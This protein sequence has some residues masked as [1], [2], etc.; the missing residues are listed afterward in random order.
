MLKPIEAPALAA[1]PN[2]E[3]GFFTR[4]GGRS[5]GIYASLNCGTGSKD[6][7][8]TVLANRALVAGHL[9]AKPGHLLTC[10]QSHTALAVAISEPWANGAAPKAD[11]IVTRT[12][13]LAVAVLAADCAPILFADLDA[14]VIGAAHA[15]WR[16]AL[17]GVLEATIKAMEDL[18]AKREHIRAALGPCIGPEAYEVGP[19]FEEQFHGSD[20]DSAAFFHLPGPDARAHF[21][22]PGYVMN[23][24]KRAGL[25]ESQSV[26]RCTYANEDHFFSFRRTT[27]RSESDYG[28][29]I[30]AIVLH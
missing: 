2:I 7:R 10:H 25:A 26:S 13:G 21:D 23:R 29:Q 30:S 16:G 14:R 6:D 19:E 9:G 8:T 17:G 11:G 28:R 1:I 4:Q 12:P 15:G 20:S 22:L 27:H 5:T 3:H 24:L 18:G